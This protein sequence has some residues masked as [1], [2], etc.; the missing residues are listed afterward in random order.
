MSDD[1]VATI[2]ST[3]EGDLPFQNYFV[4]RRC[5]PAVRRI[6]FAGAQA[7]RPAPGVLE[8]IAAP[9]TRAI[10]IAPSNPY[11]S[12]DPLLAV[13]GITDALKAS[14]APVVAVTPIVGGDAGKGPTAKLMR[15]LGIAVSPATVA[16]HYG[17]LIDGFL[18][19]SRDPDH[20][21]D[22]AYSVCDTLMH[23]P[24]DRAH[25]AA[26]ALALADRLT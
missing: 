1:P 21:I 22:I 12:V 2:V 18:V 10:L 6:A 9:D 20:G 15:E 7:A 23:S 3:D 5:A 25:V 11:L 16:A 17:D 26:A 19:D 14:A 24:E 13:P 8:A 4:A